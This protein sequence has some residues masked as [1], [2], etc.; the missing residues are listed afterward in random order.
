MDRRFDRRLGVTVHEE[1][2]SLQWGRTN[3]SY[4]GPL[5][6]AVAVEL[7][8]SDLL[9]KSDLRIAKNQVAKKVAPI[10]MAQN[11]YYGDITGDGVSTGWWFKKGLAIFLIGYDDEVLS[12]L[13]TE[14]TDSE[15]DA[16]LAAVEMVRQFNR[17][18]KKP[19]LLGGALLGL[20]TQTN[21]ILRVSGK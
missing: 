13:G 16:L 15:I 1:H 8:L 14:P 17:I 5:A 7:V 20:Q 4:A 11:S 6:N 19:L 12:I 10:L 18:I 3:F 9:S 21:F 2:D